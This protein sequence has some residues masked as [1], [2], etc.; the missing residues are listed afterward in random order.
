MWAFSLFYIIWMSVGLFD[1]WL[2]RKKAFQG[3]RL[4]FGNIL[5]TKCFIN[6]SRKQ[7][8]VASI[9]KILQKYKYSMCLQ[10]LQILTNLLSEDMI[11]IFCGML[12]SVSKTLNN[13]CWSVIWNFEGRVNLL[14]TFRWQSSPLRPLCE[15]TVCVTIVWM[16]GR[17]II[18]ALDCPKQT[19]Y[20]A[21]N[22]IYV[23]QWI[24]C[25]LK[26]SLEV[27]VVT[28]PWAVDEWMNM[29]SGS[30]ASVVPVPLKPPR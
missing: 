9:K 8:T 10:A 4:L 14:F 6:Y 26:L 7:C 11:N 30:S 18:N 27:S 16:L 19:I 2:A 29:G 1:C 12:T 3:H 24:V 21:H 22:C 28:S 5:F 17:L 20:T 23:C 13:K 15:L 25:G